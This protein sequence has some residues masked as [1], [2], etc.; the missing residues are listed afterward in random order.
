M[1]YQV[2]REAYKGLVPIT[3]KRPCPRPRPTWGLDPEVVRGGIVLLSDIM[4]PYDPTS[5]KTY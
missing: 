1:A 4:G 3:R 2:A 5:S